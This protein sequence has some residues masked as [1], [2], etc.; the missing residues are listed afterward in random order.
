M[1][2]ILCILLLSGGVSLVAQVKKKITSV[3]GELLDYPPSS[4]VSNTLSGVNLTTTVNGV[5]GAAVDIS[6]IEPWRVMG[7]S[8][9]AISNLQDIY[10]TGKVGIG[11]GNS[12]WS[13]KLQVTGN[14][15]FVG[16]VKIQ[17]GTQGAN[18]VLTSDA[19]GLA[20]WKSTA[21]DIIDGSANPGKYVE[22]TT[23]DNFLGPNITLP[24]GKWVVNLG[25][26]IS[27]KTGAG[28]VP[29]SSYSPRMTLSSSSTALQQ[30]GFS[31]N[32]S[33]LV[34]SMVSTGPVVP[35]YVTFASGAFRVNNTSGGNVTLYV[36][37]TGSINDNNSWGKETPAINDQGENYLY[38]TRAN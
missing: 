24:P 5:T 20:S 9:P 8:V 12:A 38:A 29:N 23:G 18:K 2:K 30:N 27:P 21:V 15:V 35:K 36:W 25:L 3:Y 13:E 26:L 16:S 37:N 14:S 17:D 19:S 33:R 4:T 10:Q 6:V 7:G 22:F 32:G 31:F 1:K 28:V 11:A 34:I